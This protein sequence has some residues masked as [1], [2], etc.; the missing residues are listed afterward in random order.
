MVA[1]FTHALTADGAASILLAKSTCVMP[2]SRRSLL[3]FWENT[4]LIFLS[5]MLLTSYLFRTIS[6]THIKMN[7]KNNFSYKTKF[8]TD[9]AGRAHAVNHLIRIL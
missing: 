9:R 1:P 4:L 2:F 5:D 6:I 3:R 8:S 7:C